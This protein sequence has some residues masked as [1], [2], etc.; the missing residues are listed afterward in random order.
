MA[1]LRTHVSSSSSTTNM[2]EHDVVRLR[3]GVSWTEGKAWHE[4]PAGTVGTIVHEWTDNIVEVEI[5]GT[6]ITV[7]K[8]YLEEVS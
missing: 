6:T 5:T 1:T 4:V 8:S 2:K 3:E 7:A